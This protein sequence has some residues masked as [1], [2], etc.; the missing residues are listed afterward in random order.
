M[1]NA[2]VLVT[3][4]YALLAVLM[5]VPVL[6]ISLERW[7]KWKLFE[8]LPPVI[9]IFLFPIL[10]SGLKV[11]PTA[12]PTYSAVK[13]F[14]VPL[15]II[16]MLLD[17]D[18]RSTMRVALRSV[19][20]L[21]VGA[22]GVVIG[23]IVAFFLLKGQLDPEAWRGFGALAGSWIGGTGNLAAVAEALDTPPTMMGLV[24]IADTFIFVLYF[25]VLFLAK[26]YAKQFARFTRV[27][28][29][30]ARRM[31]EAVSQLEE[32]KNDATFVDVLTLFGIGFMLIFL[33]DLVAVKL[34]TQEGVFS[35]KTWEILLLTTVALL[36]AGTPLRRVKGT[37]ALSM[38][39][40]YLYLSMIGAQADIRQ[41]AAAPYF[42]LAG[43][44][45][46]VLHLALCVLAA[47]IFRV[48]VHLT[49]VASVAAIGGAASAPVVAA[50]HK[51]ELVPVSILLAMIGYAL[52]NYLGLLAGY[53]CRAM[54]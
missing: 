10:L 53:G 29:E 30:E 13:A 15:F 44:I 43:V 37:K 7:T 36:L 17:V 35:V 16:L 47:R 28:A 34:P 32:K 14:A 49:A 4:P 19:G 46:I 40:V 25:P 2:T 23:G 22:F 20:V 27:T 48:D 18:L 38:A 3:H 52:G 54:L 1:E 5:L 50:Y 24:V 31:D 11:I 26:R 6:F 41:A 42:M 39:L 45:C 12:S 33:I 8:Y 51:K 21:V 9:W